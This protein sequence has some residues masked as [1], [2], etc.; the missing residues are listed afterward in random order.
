MRTRL[1]SGEEVAA[2]VRRHW[3]ALAGPFGL[4]SFLLGCLIAAYAVQRRYLVPAVGGALL[5]AAFWALW[6]WLVW[7][8]DIWVVTSE[9]VVDESGV[10]SVRMVDSPLD[11]IHNVTCE[12][13]LLGRMLDF[14]TLGIQTVAEAGATAIDGVAHPREVK[15]AILE[16]R[17]RYRT[18]LLGRQAGPIL[19]AAREALASGSDVGAGPGARAAGDTKECPHCAETIRARATVCRF[20]GRTI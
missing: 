8:R 1:R 4:A 6:R 19:A 14:G 3:V 7:S 15:E 16:A 11:R 13:T 18:A 12:Q 5:L 17:E 10:L 20:C 9:R 2:V